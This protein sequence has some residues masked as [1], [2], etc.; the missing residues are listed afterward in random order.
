MIG[1]KLHRGWLVSVL[2]SIPVANALADLIPI[3]TSHL[4]YLAL[5][6]LATSAVIA[7]YHHRSLASQKQQFLSIFLGLSAALLISALTLGGA[8]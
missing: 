7:T 2:I 1:L 6:L 8:R 4:A 5:L 3:L